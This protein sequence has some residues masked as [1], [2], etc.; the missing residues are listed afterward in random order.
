MG[1]EL[2]WSARRWG[3]AAGDGLAAGGWHGNRDWVLNVANRVPQL[4]PDEQTRLI[5]HFG[6]F[7]IWPGV[8]GPRFLRSGAAGRGRGGGRPWVVARGRRRVLP[9]SPTGGA[10]VSPRGT[11]GGPKTFPLSR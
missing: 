3:L 10:A 8:A 9:P 1:G 11:D 4:L 7:G 6:D 5:L 2:G